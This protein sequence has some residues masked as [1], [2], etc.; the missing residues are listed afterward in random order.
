MDPELIV[1]DR[2]RTRA[3]RAGRVDEVWEL[4]RG[5]YAERTKDQIFDLALD[6][7]WTVGKIMTA[8]EALVDPHLVARGFVASRSI[9][10]ETILHWRGGYFQPHYAP[11]PLTGVRLVRAAGGV[12][13]LAHP[14]T[15]GRG[16][17]IAEA[18][19]AELAK[20]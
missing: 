16:R 11:D 6:T 14:G 15:G 5:W 8:T 17:V 3:A 19:L 2:Y 20:R 1:D 10:F 18:H 7:P 9:A 12:P 13:V 4:V